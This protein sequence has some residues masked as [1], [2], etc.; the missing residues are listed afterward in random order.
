MRQSVSSP[1]A[2]K[3]RATASLAASMNSSII[4]YA[5]RSPGSRRDLRIVAHQPRIVVV[6]LD[7][8]LGEVEVER[9]AR[10]ARLPRICRASESIARSAGRNGSYLRRLPRVSPAQRRRDARVV[11]PRARMDHRRAEV[12]G[13]DAAR[14][15]SRSMRTTIASRSSSGTSEQMRADSGS[16]SIGMARLGR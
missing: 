15:R 5:C 3:L 8:R 14:R 4:E 1:R 10:D 12:G 13:D 9:A 16:G 7:E 2:W 6:Q 11:E